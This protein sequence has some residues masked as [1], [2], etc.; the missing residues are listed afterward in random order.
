VIEAE[1]RIWNE[2]EQIV[3]SRAF[4][5]ETM[6]DLKRQLYEVTFEDFDGENA[7][8]YKQWRADND[9]KKEKAK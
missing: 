6:K 7:E 4:E 3:V 1:L 5:A 8:A 2:N 9:L